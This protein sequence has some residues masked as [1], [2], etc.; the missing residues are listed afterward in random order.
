MAAIVSF[1]NLLQSAENDMSA[2]WEHCLKVA[3]TCA[4]CVRR[5]VAEVFNMNELVGG[6][7]NQ[8]DEHLQYQINTAAILRP[9]VHRFNADNPAISSNQQFPALPSLRP[10]PTHPQR[11]TYFPSCAF[12]GTDWLLT[13]T[14]HLT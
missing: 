12:N 2:H 8:H 13:F 11:L 5:D 9:S 1:M 6:V 4:R 7:T 14:F 10:T 3:E